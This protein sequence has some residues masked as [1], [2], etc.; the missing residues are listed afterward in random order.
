MTHQMSIKDRNGIFSTKQQVLQLE[1]ACLMSI[2][3]LKKKKIFYKKTS[4]Y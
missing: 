3:L 1:N 4:N 2:K